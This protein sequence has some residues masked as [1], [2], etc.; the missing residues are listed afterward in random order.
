MPP[1]L[2]LHLEHAGRVDGDRREAECAV[3]SEHGV[4]LFGVRSCDEADVRPVALE[5]Q[6]RFELDP[7]AETTATMLRHDRGVF[8]P[9]DGAG[10]ARD[11]QLCGRDDFPQTV[12]RNGDPDVSVAELERSLEVANEGGVPDSLLVFELMWCI[13]DRL[14]RVG[15][16]IE[17]L[18]RRGTDPAAEAVAVDRTDRQVFAKWEA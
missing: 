2:A 11:A 15:V 5:L 6:E 16:G 10:P 9:C 13:A 4:I 12:Q 7:A 14:P 18:R 1:M 8:G 3:E 17:Q